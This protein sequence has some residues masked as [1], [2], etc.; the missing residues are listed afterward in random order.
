MD[1]SLEFI[2]INENVNI[3]ESFKKI[4]TRAGSTLSFKVRGLIILSTIDGTPKEHIYAVFYNYTKELIYM[5]LSLKN[6]RKVVFENGL[7]I[8]KTKG[9]TE[10]EVC[11]VWNSI[12]HLNDSIIPADPEFVELKAFVFEDSEALSPDLHPIMD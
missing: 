1:D 8:S 2:R 3:Y 5:S 6:S 9:L 7:G 10:D 11:R 12:I 4:P